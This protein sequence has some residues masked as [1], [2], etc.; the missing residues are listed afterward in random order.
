MNLRKIYLWS[1]KIE[2]VHFRLVDL[3][4]FFLDVAW[5]LGEKV[6]RPKS[7]VTDY[8][9]I[10][11]ICG[12]VKILMSLHG[13]G[14][15]LLEH[16]LKSTIFIKCSLNIVLH[17]FCERQWLWD[18]SLPARRAT[19]ATNNIRHPHPS[20]TNINQQHISIFG[21]PRHVRLFLCR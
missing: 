5:A 12:I 21:V 14:V 20:S 16:V 7:I 1:C 17:V 10:A 9:C 18:K 6:E 19:L 4:W 15:V 2:I 8:S 11:F 3:T 13:L